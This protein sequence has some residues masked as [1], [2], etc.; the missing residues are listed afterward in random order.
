MG[1]GA[2]ASCLSL[3]RS[4]SN[5]GSTAAL[6]LSATTSGCGS[7]VSAAAAAASVSVTGVLNV[8]T[9]FANSFPTLGQTEGL[10]L[11]TLASGS[12]SVSW[13]GEEGSAEGRGSDRESP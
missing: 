4:L 10:P 8:K 5:L 12:D 1:A 13:A 11:S 6:P 9:Q 7:C 3:P 2:R